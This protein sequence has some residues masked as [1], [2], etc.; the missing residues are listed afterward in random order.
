MERGVVVRKTGG[1]LLLLTLLGPIAGTA[2]AASL[3][4]QFVPASVVDDLSQAIEWPD[5]TE[6]TRVLLLRDY[7]TR[8]VL[9]GTMLLGTTAGLVGG[10]MLLRRQALVGDVVSHASLPGI[11]LMFIVLELIN[12]GTGR[13]LPL[14][15]LGATIAGLVG[16]GLSTAIRRLTRIKDDA[17][18]AI[19]LSV[20]FGAGIVLFT[21][22]QSLPNGN[23][24]GLQHFI[25][26]R[27]A[28]MTAEDVRLIAI[29][30]LCVLLS[31]V[32][33]FKELTL[34]CFDEQYAAAQG[35]PVL[36]L[37]LTLMGLVVAV[38]VIGQQSVGLLLVVAMMIIPPAAARF[39]TDRIHRL[40]VLSGVIGCLGACLGGFISALFPKFAAGAVM[41]LMTTF[42]FAVS[43]LLGARRGVVWRA[44]QHRSLSRRVATHDLLRSIFEL[45]EVRDEGR[46]PISI[47]SLSG[48]QVSMQEVLRQ[49]HWDQRRLA[50]A[51]TAA[52][53]E[54]WLKEIPDSSFVLTSDGANE[55][56]EII[57]NH[58]MWEI[59]LIENADVAPAYVDRYVDRIEHV[60]DPEFMETVNSELQKR[61]PGLAVPQSPHQL[62]RQSE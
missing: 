25:F 54:A 30:S 38:S 59:F 22:V 40:A 35:W 1:A 34:L 23:A 24:A 49:R 7:N 37:D 55:A 19:V 52:R 27:A 61:Y 12:P 48:A 16:I 15:S 57:R 2:S 6:L 31:C 45:I 4:R 36:G 44:W 43:M 17:A 62:E 29:S 3:H 60:V 58:R 18:L 47:A 26:G 9:L 56:I 11:A 20:F 32:F 5:G 13:N 50:T 14:L 46:A 39:W 33:L 8:I 53:R 10:F 42:L 41:V 51:L 21:I 28:S